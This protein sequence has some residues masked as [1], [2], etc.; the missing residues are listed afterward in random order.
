MRAM[1]KRRKCPSLLIFHRIKEGQK[2]R[3]PLNWKIRS[4]PFLWFFYP[5]KTERPT[6]FSLRLVVH[7]LCFDQLYCC[8][9][10]LFSSLCTLVQDNLA[11][12][13]PQYDVNTCWN[14]N[15]QKEASQR[16]ASQREAS[17][18]RPTTPTAKA[19]YWGGVPPPKKLKLNLTS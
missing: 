15:G 5:S 3:S 4:P 14:L 1:G 11:P 17:R 13:L 12:A 9:C 10:K 7:A 2:R 8:T 18:R 16:E 19:A 6:A